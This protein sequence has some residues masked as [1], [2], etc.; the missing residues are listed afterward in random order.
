M[1]SV[2]CEAI[3]KKLNKKLACII[4]CLILLVLSLEHYVIFPVFFRDPGIELDFSRFP[5]FVKTAKLKTLTSTEAD[6]LTTMSRAGQ[7]T[8]PEKVQD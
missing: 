5:F 1:P 4:A 7:S 3:Q 6:A 2:F 8:G